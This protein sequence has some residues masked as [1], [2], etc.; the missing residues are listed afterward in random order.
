MPGPASTP[1]ERV[2][3]AKSLLASR[4]VRPW[5]VPMQPRMGWT[6]L[7]AAIEASH[8]ATDVA[9]IRRHACVLERKFSGSDCSQAGPS[10]FHGQATGS[11]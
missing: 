8:M 10:D 2:P 3:G 6:G 1:A 5:I 11:C 9:H 4:R 7:H